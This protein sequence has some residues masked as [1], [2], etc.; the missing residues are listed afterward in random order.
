M[1]K[2]PAEQTW[3]ELPRDGPCVVEQLFG[4]AVLPCRGSI[5][6]HHIDRMSDSTVQVCARHHPQLEAALRFLKKPQT[7]KSCPHRPGT[8]RYAAGKEACERLLNRELLALGGSP[9]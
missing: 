3:R 6:R 8:H 7:W 5:H 4:E 2:E 9:N 1:L